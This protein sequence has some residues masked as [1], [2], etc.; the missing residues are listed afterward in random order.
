M[1]PAHPHSGYCDIQGRRRVIEDFHAIRLSS[2]QQFYGIF[3]G[4]TGNL[5][6]KYVASFLYNKLDARL[7]GI[8]HSDAL[9]PDWK[10]Q[11][12]ESVRDVFAEIHEGFL[13]ATSLIPHAYMDQ[14]GSTATAA[15]VTSSAIIVASLGDSR[16][17]LS[18]YDGMNR[19]SA[20]Q[21]TKDHVASDPE[22]RLLVE[23]RRGKVLVT[24]GVSR[25]EGVLAI[26]RSIGGT[27]DQVF[28]VP[29]A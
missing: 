4:H 28:F 27:C 29:T 7:S 8:L 14:S 9:P 6:S 21:L 17:I 22:E 11:V 13:N 5:A 2:T 20:M 12:N 18:S 23:A 26:T 24:N 10:Q 15:F 16:A 19:L 3:D 25:V 1:L